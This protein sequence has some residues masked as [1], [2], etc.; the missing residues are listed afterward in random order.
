MT[1]CPRT[2][3]MSSSSLGAFANCL[4]FMTRDSNL[5]EFRFAM[6]DAGWVAHNLPSSVGTP[7][8][9]YGGRPRAAKTRMGLGKPGTKLIHGT[10]RGPYATSRV[11]THRIRVSI[12]FVL[13]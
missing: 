8:Q 3:R 12:E 10:E 1:F 2:T 11:D 13:M 4:S 7:C 6:L 9:F 5:I